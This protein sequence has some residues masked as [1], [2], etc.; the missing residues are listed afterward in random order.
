MTRFYK[1]APTDAD[2]PQPT[3]TTTAPD[4]GLTSI[5]A[6]RTRPDA[7]PTRNEPHPRTGLRTTGTDTPA[8]PPP[9]PAHQDRL[10]RP[11]LE[12]RPSVSRPT[13]RPATTET[14]RPRPDPATPTTPTTAPP[15]PTY[16]PRQHPAPTPPQHPPQATAKPHRPRNRNSPT[17]PAAESDAPAP[18]RPQHP[19]SCRQPT[20]N[21]LGHRVILSR[22]WGIEGNHARQASQALS[23]RNLSQN[24][25]DKRNVRT[26]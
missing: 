18:H 4:S 20:R 19:R 1:A 23:T 5:T 25:C 26:D 11:Q 17:A 10:P 7:P 24:E 21:R 6:R 2:S 15:T 9:T 16:P 13:E 22:F 14:P 8:R 3:P 12:T